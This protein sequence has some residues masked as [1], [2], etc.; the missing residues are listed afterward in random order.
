MILV[1]GVLAVWAVVVCVSTA[2]R[3]S[4]KNAYASDDFAHWEL[5]TLPPRSLALVSYFQTSFRAAALQTTEHSRPDL[6]VLDRSFLTYP[7]MAAQAA[8]KHPQFASLIDSPLRA[9]APTPIAKLREISKTRPV[10]MQLH[11]NIEAETATQLIPMG[12]FAELETIPP[13]RQQ[14]DQGTRIDHAQRVI[15]RRRISDAAPSERMDARLAGLWYDAMRLRHYCANGQKRAAQQALA[16]ASRYFST[17]VV[18]SS[19]A[20]RCGLLPLQ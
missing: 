6:V 9:G 19:E 17:D 5:D 18:L 16:D 14:R 10:Y 12:A 2:H 20:Q 1:V 4:L 11:F 7:G 15:L 3:A 13:T 8:A